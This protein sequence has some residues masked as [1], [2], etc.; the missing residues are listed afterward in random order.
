MER[1]NAADVRRV[2]KSL[3]LDFSGKKDLAIK[4]MEESLKILWDDSKEK[5]MESI[6]KTI[7]E[8]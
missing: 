3:L 5:K 8:D 4:R 6:A 2:Q 7:I 1:F